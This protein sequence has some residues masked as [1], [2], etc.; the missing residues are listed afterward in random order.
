MTIDQL[1]EEHRIRREAIAPASIQAALSRARSDLT[2]AESM[3]DRDP[4]WAFSIAYHAVLQAS[5]ALMFRH[6]FRPA[7]HESHA[8]TF[9][10]LRCAVGDEKQSLVAFFDRMRVKR[11]QAVYES[12]DSITKTE[13]EALIA[14]A[15]EFIAWVAEAV[16]E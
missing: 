1:L 3:L 14:Q 12:A 16:T 7:S 9:A 8:N 15:Q 4:R 2:T 5:R 11:H 10:Y 13:A 6:G